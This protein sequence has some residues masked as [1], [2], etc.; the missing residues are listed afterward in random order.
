LHGPWFLLAAALVAATPSLCRAWSWDGVSWADYRAYISPIDASQKARLRTIVASGTASGRVLGRM[1]QI[2]DS[3]TESSAYFRNAI[4]GGPTSNETGHD[5]ASIRSWLAYSGTQP[6]DGSSFYNN[7]GKD[8][9]WGNSSGW[10]LLEA[11]QAGHP[12]RGV[13]QGDLGVPG[14]YSWVLI[15]FGT[16]DI[17]SFWNPTIWKPMYHDF[18]Q[19]Y[20]DLGVV[21]VLSTIPPEQAHI[22][23]NNVQEANEVVKQLAAE[24]QIPWVDYYSLILHFQPVNWVGTLIGNDGTHP[25][26]GTGGQGFSQTAQSST[27]GYALRTKLT[28]DMAEKLRTIVFDNGTPDNPLTDFPHVSQV[29]TPDIEI[30]PNPFR[31]ETWVRT[32]RGAGEL[33][34]VDAAG[35]M[36]RHFA[37]QTAQSE[38]VE[39][40]WDARD[41]LGQPVAAGVYFAA[42]TLGREVQTA[43][44]V[45]IR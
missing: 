7:Y 5:Y 41:D 37:D 8:Y 23:D 11:I 20:I 17:D 30:H 26:A 2:G 34:I 40:E 27:D 21:P 12:S 13:L 25:S 1:G 24:M 31:E 44:V 43:R 16:N 3:I 4:L 38:R 33:R 42:W 45:L 15:M 29:V 32:P 22:G 14:Q 28:L 6:A 35:R 10:N 18:I 9:H 39:R 36:V 19:G